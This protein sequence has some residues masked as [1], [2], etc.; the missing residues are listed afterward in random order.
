MSG[1]ETST[2]S[3]HGNPAQFHDCKHP[4]GQRGT[5]D[6][7]SPSL[8]SAVQT[9]QLLQQK[10]MLAANHGLADNVVAALE[11]GS[12]A[13]VQWSTWGLPPRYPSIARNIS[14]ATYEGGNYNK[15]EYMNI[16]ELPIGSGGTG[17]GS[18]DASV[19]HEHPSEWSIE[20]MPNSE[21][22]M[23]FRP[24]GS[25]PYP[26]Q[27]FEDTRNNPSATSPPNNE[28]LL[29]QNNYG[30]PSKYLFAA[31][32]PT[33]EFTKKVMHET[34]GFGKKQHTRG[35]GP[36]RTCLIPHVI[37][38]RTNEGQF[39]IVKL[40]GSFMPLESCNQSRHSGELRVMLARADG[41][42]FGGGLAGPMMAASSVLIVLGRFLPNGGNVAMLANNLFM[43]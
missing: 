30:E 18:H 7:G 5:G 19:L 12:Q 21:G 42:V 15:Q 29:K 9:N 1:G 31:V 14:E 27:G 10:D 6:S 25:H 4:H 34:G 8:L 36:D 17:S 33:T 32:T 11:T 2:V 22:S 20:S 35:P 43:V 3:K 41:H 39:D 23:I 24:K 37:T 16:L 26:S 13:D 38:I 40:S 28:E